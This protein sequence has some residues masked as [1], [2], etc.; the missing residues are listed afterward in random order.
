MDSKTPAT[1]AGTSAPAAPAAPADIAG[2]AG[3]N[4]PTVIE[5]GNLNKT[6]PLPKDM[7][8]M[9][10]DKK[11]RFC[12]HCHTPKPSAQV[13]IEGKNNGICVNCV[14]GINNYDKLVGAAVLPPRPGTHIVPL[15][16]IRTVKVVRS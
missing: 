14:N 15:E 5:F 11:Y 9:L 2:T 13:P 4:A 7:E 10:G 3:A 6:F 1:P 16:V 8:V 12:T